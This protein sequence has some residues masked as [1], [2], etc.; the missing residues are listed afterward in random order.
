MLY[1]LEADPF[2]QNNLVGK[3]PAVEAVLDKRLARWMKDTGD[4]WSFNWKHSVEDGGRLYK[5]KTFYTI[6][7][8]M[9]WARQHPE[10]DK[11]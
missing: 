10:L 7:E 8:Y 4:A 6:E 1:D 5:Y 3:A 9:E 11:V 2:Q